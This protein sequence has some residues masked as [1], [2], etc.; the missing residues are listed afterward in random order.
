MLTS[1]MDFA[2]MTKKYPDI[3]IREYLESDFHYLASNLR[4]IDKKELEALFDE[5]VEA[6]LK[7]SI[8]SA[9][10]IWVAT[11]KQIPCMIFGV[12]DRTEEGECTRSGLVWALGTNEVYKHIKALH[13]ISQNVLNHWFEEYDVLFNYIWDENE[14]HKAWLKNLGFIIFEEEYI[15]SKAEEKFVFF[16][17]YSPNYLEEQ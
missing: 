17:L 10:H 9:D 3:Q 11:H 1:H 7:Y 12:S 5:E 13:E 2:K 4:D 8:E 16:A 6:G 14:L 15:I